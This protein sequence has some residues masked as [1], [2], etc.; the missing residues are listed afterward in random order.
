[1]ECNNCKFFR[2]S[3]SNIICNKCK[4]FIEK[5][6]RV[7]NTNGEP[8]PFTKKL[9]ALTKIFIRKYLLSILTS[10]LIVFGCDASY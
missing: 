5:A 2:N 4:N 9:L 10:C 8:E 1:M 7:Y 6:S 3:T